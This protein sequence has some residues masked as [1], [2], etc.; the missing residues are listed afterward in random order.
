MEDWNN[1]FPH[2]GEGH[3]NCTGLGCDCD[4]KNYGYY[5][6]GN[7]K[8]SSGSGDKIFWIGFIVAVIIGAAFNELVGAMIMIGVA[9]YILARC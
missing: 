9:I 1:P 4:E 5:S 2:D 6:S 3:G 7:N 8:N